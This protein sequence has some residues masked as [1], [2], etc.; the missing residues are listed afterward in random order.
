MAARSLRLVFENAADAKKNVTITIPQCDDTKAAQDIKS[1]MEVI[2]NNK[3]IFSLDIGTPKSAA[4]VTPLSLT[5]VDISG[6]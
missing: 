1:A 2:Y 6:L 4:F 5:Q 3:G